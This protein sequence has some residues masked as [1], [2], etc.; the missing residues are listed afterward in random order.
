MEQVEQFVTFMAA[1]ELET[2]MY[3]HEDYPAA[4]MSA[5]ET[6]FPSQDFSSE[7]T[8]I[9]IESALDLSWTRGSPSPPTMGA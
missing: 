3:E 5:I 8:M 6:S 1:C 2:F 4:P 9:A 7:G